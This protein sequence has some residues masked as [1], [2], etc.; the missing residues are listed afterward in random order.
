MFWRFSGFKSK[1]FKWDLLNLGHRVS[2]CLWNTFWGK[3]GL[4][5]WTVRGAVR[6][7]RSNCL[8]GTFRSLLFW[9]VNSAS[10][11]WIQWW[12]LAVGDIMPS[13]CGMM[14]YFKQLCGVRMS[15]CYCE[16][17]YVLPLILSWAFSSHPVLSQH[18]WV[19]QSICLCKQKN[20]SFFPCLLY[21]TC[22]KGNRWNF[23]WHELRE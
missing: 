12:H 20:Q 3:L 6:R 17:S 11:K 8:L 18:F 10:N 23:L 14:V 5:C 21:D 1:K 15:D 7:K 19:L 2:L 13:S 4:H 22:M 16:F 9:L